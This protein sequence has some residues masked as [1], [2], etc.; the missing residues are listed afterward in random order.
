MLVLVTILVLVLSRIF[1]GTTVSYSELKPSYSKFLELQSNPDVMN[2]KCTV[3]NDTLTYDAFTSYAF[4]KADA[5]IWVN[6][7]LS[8]E[9]MSYEEDKYALFDNSTGTTFESYILKRSK[10]G[11]TSACKVL[12]KTSTCEAIKDDCNRGHELIENLFENMERSNFP[13]KELLDGESKL[14]TFVNATLQQSLES[15]FSGLKGPRIA[16]QQWASKNMPALYGYFGSLTNYVQAQM[17]HLD[18]TSSPTEFYKR[19]RAACTLYNEKFVGKNETKC[20]YRTIGDGWCNPECNNPYCLNDGG[21]CLRGE[22]LYTSSH[23]YWDENDDEFKYRG[24]SPLQQGDESLINPYYDI[25]N[26]TTY[27][28][29]VTDVLKGLDIFNTDAKWNKFKESEEELY[30]LSIWQSLPNFFAGVDPD[31]TCGNPNTWYKPYEMD[32]PA[33]WLA[34]LNENAEFVYDTVFRDVVFPTFGS[35]SG[36]SRPSGDIPVQSTDVF[37]CDALSKSHNIPGVSGFTPAQIKSWIDYT[38]ALF[39]YFKVKCGENADGDWKTDCPTFNITDPKGNEIKNVRFPVAFL[40]DTY[41]H[42]DFITILS[43]LEYAYLGSLAKMNSGSVEQLLLDAGVKRDSKGYNV[44]AKVDYEKYYA[45]SDVSQCTYSKKIGASPATVVTVVLG[46]IGGVTTSASVVTL[47]LY[48]I[49][50]KRVF[51]KYNNNE[52][53]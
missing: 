4:E 37:S 29:N 11:L 47:I 25:N 32:R 53:K 6:T 1:K 46:L 39:D 33:T 24:F 41:E 34:N 27:D 48:K 10:L 22:E 8:K 49:M 38:Y 51:K 52:L 30:K 12:K 26:A 5:C 14:S 7:D 35:P 20:D 17:F 3:S 31:D 28:T 16:V 45:A 23:A 18:D 19:V 43:H 44:E 9:G 2:L 42:Y 50:R 15:L 13:L 40:S 36:A 21:D